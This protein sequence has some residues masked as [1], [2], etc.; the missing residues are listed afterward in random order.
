MKKQLHE[1]EAE[2]L[3]YMKKSTNI[4]PERKVFSKIDDAALGWV[5]KKRKT[6]PRLQGTDGLLLNTDYLAARSQAETASRVLS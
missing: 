4:F 2:L 6:N 5:H 3:K 1:Q